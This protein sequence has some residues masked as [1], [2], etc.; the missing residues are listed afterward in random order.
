MWGERPSSV[1]S[2]ALV[3]VFGGTNDVPRPETPWR[4][5]GRTGGATSLLT[6]SGENDSSTLSNPTTQGTV[7]GWVLT[8]THR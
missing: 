5:G 4:E 7:L 1:L 3:C 6:L 8:G 2:F